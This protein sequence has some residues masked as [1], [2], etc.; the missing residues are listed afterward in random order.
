MKGRKERGVKVRRGEQGGAVGGRDAD[1]G[2][3]VRDE[4]GGE[5]ALGQL[6]AGG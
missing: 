1:A 6:W 2:K 4:A 3:K 5:V